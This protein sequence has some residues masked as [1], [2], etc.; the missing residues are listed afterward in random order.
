VRRPGSASGDRGGAF[1]VLVRG[2]NGQLRSE[3]FADPVTYRTRIAALEQSTTG[4]SLADVSIDELA[5][6][7]DSQR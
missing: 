2:T 7:L 3:R 5:A 4:V 1:Q 6:W